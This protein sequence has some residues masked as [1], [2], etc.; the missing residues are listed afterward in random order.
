MRENSRLCTTGQ[1]GEESPSTDFTVKLLL[2]DTDGQRIYTCIVAQIY[3]HLPTSPRQ[4]GKRAGPLDTALD[5]RFFKALADPTRLRLL[6]CLAKCARSC[7]VTEISQCCDTDFSVVSRHLAALARAEILETSKQGRTVYY[8][9]CYS[10]VSEKLRE[11]AGAFDDCCSPA[12]SNCCK[13]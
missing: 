5:A 10:A 1:I 4:A 2:V 11:I 3:K 13:R 12:G 9:V 8:R 7:S 6:S